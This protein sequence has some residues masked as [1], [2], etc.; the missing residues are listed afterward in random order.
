MNFRTKITEMAV[1][2]PFLNID[3]SPF[4]LPAIPG[5]RNDKD[6]LPRNRFTRTKS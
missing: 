1:T 2:H 3:P 5:K 6:C 4:F